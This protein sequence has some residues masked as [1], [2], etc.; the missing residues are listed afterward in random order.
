M[1]AGRWAGAE[2]PARFTSSKRRSA[3]A[4][5]YSGQAIA[6]HRM[7]AAGNATGLLAAELRG[8]V[9]VVDGCSPTRI[10]ERQLLKGMAFTVKAARREAFGG[11]LV[12]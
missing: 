10:E 8:C 1:H 7:R 2:P 4:E 9:R 6:R 5:R 12:A 3:I 11:S